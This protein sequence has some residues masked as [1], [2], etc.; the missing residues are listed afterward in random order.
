MNHSPSPYNPS[1]PAH[2]PDSS[3]IDITLS[4]RGI[5]RAGGITV[6]LAAMLAACVEDATDTKPARVGDAA[7]P[8]PLPEAVLSDGVLFRTE[9]SLHYSVIRAHKVAMEV[10]EL[11]ADQ[12]AV[13]EA[14]V[15][16]HQAAI[17]ELQKLTVEAGS[18]AWTCSNPR[19][20]RI[21]VDVL[22]GRITGRPKQGTE[23]GDVAPS[24]NPNR[25]ALA[26][27]FGMESVAAATHQ[28]LVPS[29]S[30]PRYRAASMQHGLAAARRA[31]AMALVINPDNTVN[32][33]L[34]ESA[35][36]GDPNVTTVVE[37][38]TTLQNLA[39]SQ[40]EDASG[41]GGGATADVITA[42][43][44]YYAVPSQF[45]TLSAFQLSVG[46]PSSGNQFT[47]NIET[48]SINSFIFDYQ[49]GC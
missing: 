46:A 10:A 34:L 6:A 13:I 24:D 45:G 31:A 29:F 22:R 14:F 8:E 19:F 41:G 33:S 3:I 1:S 7:A 5:F 18:H 30:K 11:A 15:T 9:T 28:S 17:A 38:T 16:G 27:V 47:L 42:P 26:M 25:D 40:D 49:D 20:D 44:V 48:P 37:T 21:V 12:T 36:L 39:Q 23:E 2:D 43:Q 35:N 4:R 32:Q